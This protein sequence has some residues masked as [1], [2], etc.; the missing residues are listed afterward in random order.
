[1]RRRSSAGSLA[2]IARSTLAPQSRVHV[3]GNGR[4][5]AGP[6]QIVAHGELG[7]RLDAEVGVRIAGEAGLARCDRCLSP[8][9]DDLDPR[10]RPPRGPEAHADE[11]PRHAQLVRLSVAAAERQQFLDVV[12][13]HEEVD[14][15]GR[16]AEQLVAQRAPDLV[17]LAE[18][19]LRHAA[20]QFVR[21]L[22]T[23]L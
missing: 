4:A 3:I 9:R 6:L 14:V 1:M 16:A 19:Q 13:A 12:P 17:Q 20:P 22:A 11:P 23:R 10:A 2:A 5:G 8:R 7:I 18:R 21:H 15:L